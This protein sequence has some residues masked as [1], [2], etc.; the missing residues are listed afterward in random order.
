MVARHLNFS[1]LGPAS[2]FPG[3]STPA[4]VGEEIILVL[5]GLGVP[6]GAPPTAG[7]ATQSGT[8]NA[9]ACWISGIPVAL[10]TESL[11]LISPGLYQLNLVIPPGTPSGDNPINCVY[12]GYPTFQGAL[13]A[14][15]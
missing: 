6:N 5:Y 1:L 14:V 2:L 3:S 7:S 9:P 11:N 8:L 15:Q 13:I 12:Q 4:A 10:A